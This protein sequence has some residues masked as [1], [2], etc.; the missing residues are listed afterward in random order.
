MSRS[1]QGL[2]FAFVDAVKKGEIQEPFSTADLKHFVALHSWDYSERYLNVLLANGASATHS[3][4]YTKCFKRVGRGQ[5]VL[6]DLA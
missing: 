5:Y 6:S 1:E 3:L 4:T 2:S